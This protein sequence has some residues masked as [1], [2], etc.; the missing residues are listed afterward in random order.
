MPAQESRPYS[1]VST[2]LCSKRNKSES[3]DLTHE[4]LRQL[5]DFLVE[6]G[7]LLQPEGRHEALHHRPL[8]LLE[9]GFDDP[10]GKAN[11]E[12]HKRMFSATFTS[13]RPDRDLNGGI[14]LIYGKT[15]SKLKR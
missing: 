4:Q 12:F 13:R 6:L 5:H 8:C 2:G 15:A 7:E 3:G 14:Y 11:S 10:V 1:R 9:K